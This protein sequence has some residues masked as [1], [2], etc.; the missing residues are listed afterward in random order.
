[1]YVGFHHLPRDFER[2]VL[3]PV[4]KHGSCARSTM[5]EVISIAAAVENSAFGCR[6]QQFDVLAYLPLPHR[7]LPAIEAAISGKDDHI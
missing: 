7:K 4:D 2:F 1:M 3:Q 5:S 6:F